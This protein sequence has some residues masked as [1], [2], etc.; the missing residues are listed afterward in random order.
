M[1]QLEIAE[2]LREQ[3]KEQWPYVSTILALYENNT[4]G[5]FSTRINIMVDKL[6]PDEVFYSSSLIFGYAESIKKSDYPVILG[7]NSK[8][9]TLD[10]NGEIKSLPINIVLFGSKD[11]LL[12]ILK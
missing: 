3:I 2:K 10:K 5:Q 6:L 12:G 9:Y 7:N 4:K 8:F 11:N 1:T